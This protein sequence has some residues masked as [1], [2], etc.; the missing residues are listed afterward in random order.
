[1]ITCV[2]TTKTDILGSIQEHLSSLSGP[3]DSFLEDHLHDSHH[4][5]IQVDGSDAG[6]TSIFKEGL[7]VQF[8]LRNEARRYGEEAFLRVRK[9]ES[10]RGA[11]VPTSDQFFLSHALDNFSRLTKQ[12]YLFEP[13]VDSAESGA[14]EGYELRLATLD[15]LV[16]IKESTGDDFLDDPERHI[17]AREVYLT[18]KDSETVGFGIIE[19]SIYQPQ[20]ASLGMFTIESFRRTGVGSS[21]MRL[22]VAKS[23]ELKVNPVSGCWYYNHDSRKTLEKAGMVSCGRYLR[24]EF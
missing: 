11:L 2:P 13:G 1:M 9:M 16:L 20:T 17:R 12:A 10:V 8:A 21:T 3:I 22:L 7:I 18:L 14:V 5:L 19:G 4:Y 24:V 15:D 23:R 6:Y